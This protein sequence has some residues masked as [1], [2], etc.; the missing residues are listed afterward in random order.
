VKSGS[1]IPVRFPDA[2]EKKLR[3]Y[4]VEND[5]SL[6]DAIRAMVSRGLASLE[7]PA[8]PEATPKRRVLSRGV[9]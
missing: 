6:S 3:L 5:C 1:P 9:G 7:P 4:A 8:P 2:V